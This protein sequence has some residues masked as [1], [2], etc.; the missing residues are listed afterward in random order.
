MA[1]IEQHNA[2]PGEGVKTGRLGIFLCLEV[3]HNNAFIS[4]LDEVGCW[5][6]GVF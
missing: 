3:D 1:T 6:G 5:I 2:E 4:I